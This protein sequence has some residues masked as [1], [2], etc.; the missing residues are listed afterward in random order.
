MWG[1][2]CGVWGVGCGA[3][4]VGMGCVMCGCVGCVVWA[5]DIGGSSLSKR[6]ARRE[7]EEV[8]QMQAEG[9]H[10]RNKLGCS[11]GSNLWPPPHS[12]SHSDHWPIT[13]WKVHTKLLQV[14]TLAG[15]TSRQYSSATVMPGGKQRPHMVRGAHR[16]Q[17]ARAQGEERTQGVG[18]GGRGVR[19]SNGGPET[20]VTGRC[21]ARGAQETR[22]GMGERA[23]GV[24]GATG[25]DKGARQ[26]SSP[27]T[28]RE[29]G[30]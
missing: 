28:L 9:G 29:G 23:R 4:G 16:Q 14:S 2:G 1:V 10:D 22:Y 15:G 13:N 21:G 17:G 20:N 19:A 8:Q 7:T 3:G 5:H 18:G 25:L 12:L 11:V 27:R 30:G 24:L 26:C 6:S